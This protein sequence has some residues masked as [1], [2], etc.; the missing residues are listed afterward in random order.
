MKVD[1]L[2]SSTPV[3]PL[4]AAFVA[5]CLPVSE[6]RFLVTVDAEQLLVVVLLFSLQKHL[7]RCIVQI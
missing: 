5:G 3:P 6:S 4:D 2:S 7:F 1:S